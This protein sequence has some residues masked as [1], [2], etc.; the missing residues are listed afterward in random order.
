MVPLVGEKRKRRRRGSGRGRGREEGEE[1]G[2]GDDSAVMVVGGGGAGGSSSSSSTSPS[3]SILHD[4]S[5]AHPSYLEGGSG[6]RMAP[7]PP[8]RRS[9]ALQGRDIMEEEEYISALE[10]IISRDFFPDVSKLKAQLMWL[11]RVNPADAGVARRVLL[12]SAQRSVPVD[13]AT[14]LEEALRD[15]EAYSKEADER[16]WEMSLSEFVQRHSTEDNESFQ[17]LLEDMQAEHRRRYWWAYEDGLDGQARLLLLPSGERNEGDRQIQFRK[18]IEENPSDQR[19]V[20]PTMWKHRAQNQLMFPPRI[21]DSIDTCGGLRPRP[22]QLLLQ[23]RVGK[24]AGEPKA[25]QHH[26]TRLQQ[27]ADGRLAVHSSPAPSASGPSPLEAPGS[28]RSSVVGLEALEG[29]LGLKT[30][31]LTQLVP[32]TP[33]I[34]PGFGGESPM[35]TWGDIASTP[36]FLDAPSPGGGFKMVDQPR[37]ERLAHD[38]QRKKAAETPQRRRQEEAAGRKKTRTSLTPAA[39]SLARRIGGVTRDGSRTPFGGGLSASASVKSSPLSRN[40][41]SGTG[42]TPHPSP[43]VPSSKKAASLTKSTAKGTCLTDGLL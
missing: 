33:T 22:G 21:E 27:S 40:R 15:M 29:R 8:R 1:G 14:A 43:A 12:S 11:Q 20:A 30:A 23:G 42:A 35:M 7:P 36:L 2:A 5:K 25:I 38:L 6:A 32:M 10:S 39:Q 31:D 16:G 41:R 18:A 17:K 28:E 37:R 24:A 19:P 4:M 9:E 13:R 3:P 26:A 34:V